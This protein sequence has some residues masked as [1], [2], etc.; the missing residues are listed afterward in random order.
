MRNILRC[1][2]LVV[3]KRR[4]LLEVDS[5]QKSPRPLDHLFKCLWSQSVNVGHR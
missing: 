5:G 3:G 1:H 2:L 4:Q